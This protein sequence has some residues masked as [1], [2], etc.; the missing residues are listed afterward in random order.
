[1]NLDEVQEYVEMYNAACHVLTKKNL[2]QYDLA[3]YLMDYIKTMIENSDIEGFATKINKFLLTLKEEELKDKDFIRF[4][5]VI[6]KEFRLKGSE[7]AK[8]IILKTENC[9]ESTKVHLRSLI[10]TVF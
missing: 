4:F 2:D 1:M 3:N 9:E 7:I 8:K 6:V 10:N 5:T